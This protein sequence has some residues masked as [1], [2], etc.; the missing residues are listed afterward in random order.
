MNIR[1]ILVMVFLF[2]A[3][4]MATEFLVSRFEYASALTR[5]LL[6]ILFLTQ[7]CIIIYLLFETRVMYGDGEGEK[8]RKE[9]GRYEP[10]SQSDTQEGR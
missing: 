6:R 8:N 1:Q 7:Y 10:D 4:C 9:S 3:G 2:G 5:Y